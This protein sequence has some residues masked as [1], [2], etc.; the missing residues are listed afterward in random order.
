MANLPL[1]MGTSAS[2]SIVEYDEV[3]IANSGGS[4]GRSEY[5]Y[6]NKEETLPPGAT[7]IEGLPNIVNTSNGL[8]DLENHYAHGGQL[9]KSVDYFYGRDISKEIRGLAFKKLNHTIRISAEFQ[10]KQVVSRIRQ[11]KGITLLQIVMFY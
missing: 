5:T 1:G 9:R 6:I 10:L 11:F 2:E 8:L 4:Y 7:F 3:T